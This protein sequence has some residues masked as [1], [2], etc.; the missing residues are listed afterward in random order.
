MTISGYDMDAKRDHFLAATRCP[1]GTVW[2]PISVSNMMHC[3][4][5]RE[6]HERG[7]VRTRE[8]SE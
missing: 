6:E 5:G 4:S 7:E 1:D 2:G 8:M 3:D